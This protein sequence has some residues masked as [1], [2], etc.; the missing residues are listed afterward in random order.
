M[1]KH[2]VDHVSGRGEQGS[3]ATMGYFRDSDAGSP[4]SHVALAVSDM[5]ST[6]TRDMQICD[7]FSSRAV[8]LHTYLN[9]IRDGLRGSA[10][11]RHH[12]TM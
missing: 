11:S 7:G 6:S 2:I 4:L 10:M 5:T 12:G 3:A 1:I 8:P 9:G